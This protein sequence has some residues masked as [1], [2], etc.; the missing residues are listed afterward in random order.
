MR[1]A[2]KLPPL[3]DEKSVTVYNLEQDSDAVKIGQLYQRSRTLLLDSVRA[4]IECGEALIAKKKEIRQ[5]GGKWLSWLE[6]NAKVLG[7]DNRS[8]ASRLMKAAKKAAANGALTHHL[9]EGNVVTASR[10]LWDNDKNYRTIGTGN[11]EWNTPEDCLIAVRDV[12]GTIDLDPASNSVAQRTVKATTYFTIA[13]DGLTKDWRGKLFLNPPYE[14]S[15]IVGFVSKLCEEY[16]VGHVSEAI[17]LTHNNTDTKWF[18]QAA[19]I[20]SVLCLTEGRI[21]FVDSAGNLAAPPNG[22]VF[23]YLG[24]RPQVFSARFSKLGLIVAVQ[25]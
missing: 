3:G 1:N 15:A 11:N 20:A 12:L 23:F 22:Q 10:Q 19:K 5:N 17:M 7:F 2:K 8:T 4:Y 21:Q 9:N 14:H 13:Q 16:T 24:N 25:S 6:A 18:H